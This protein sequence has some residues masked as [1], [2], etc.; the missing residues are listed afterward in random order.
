MSQ[1]CD[2]LQWNTVCSWS[3]VAKSSWLWW[4]FPIASWLNFVFWS[5]TSQLWD[6]LSGISVQTFMVLKGWTPPDFVILLT[7]SSSFTSRLSYCL[8]WHSTTV[9]RIALKFSTDIHGSLW[10]Y[11]VKFDCIALVLME[12]EV[13]CVPPVFTLSALQLCIIYFSH[14]GDV[15]RGKYLNN[16]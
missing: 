15:S 12:G 5:K 7:F 2:V 3:P 10:M 8:L 13:S 9:G 1:L 4:S 14:A 6:V 16:C 11:P